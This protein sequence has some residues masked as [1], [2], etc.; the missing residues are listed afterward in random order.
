MWGK[1]STYHRAI[2]AA[3]FYSCAA[4]FLPAFIACQLSLSEPSFN[5]VFLPLLQ[6]TPTRSFVALACLG[7]RLTGSD[8]QASPEHNLHV[9]LPA[10][11]C[12]TPCATC[13]PQQ[14]NPRGWKIASNQPSTYGKTRSYRCVHVPKSHT[15]D[16]SHPS[17]NAY[18]ACT[19]ARFQLYLHPC[20]TCH[21]QQ[22]QRIAAQAWN[23]EMR[24]KS[25]P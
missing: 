8:T 15:G 23:P 4:C 6:S 17:K 1:T 19:P 24:L 18:S 3:C 12:T 9:P 20:T 10:F 5:S 2:S 14:I 13:H 16:E 22:R 25:I 11:S 7:E 21:P